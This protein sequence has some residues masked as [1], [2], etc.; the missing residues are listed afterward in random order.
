MNESDDEDAHLFREAVRGVK[1]LSGQPDVARG[2]RP[3]PR[4]R[5]A[6]AD[7][8]AVLQ[9]SLG[10]DAG[11][12]EL[13]SGEELVFQRPGVQASVVRKLRRGQY[14]VQAEIDLH[15]LTVA[16]AKEALRDFLAAALSRNLHCVRI[17]HGKGLR[18][19]HR[20][21]V[22]KGAVSS[23]LR[24]IGPVLAYVSARQVDGGTGA[25]Y[26]LLAR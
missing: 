12:P 16:E 17:V 20:G 22:L 18:S 14:R 4:A 21:P 24:R 10:P 6:R 2:R 5:F 11:D 25:L 13:A 9:E 7:R 3:A 26:V 1:P 15:G 23:V 19:G 8:R